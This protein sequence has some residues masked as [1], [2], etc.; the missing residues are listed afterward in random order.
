MVL[1][2]DLY[3]RL[4]ARNDIENLIARYCIACDDRRIEEL[5][6]MFTE[7]AYFGHVDG[8]HG[9]SGRDGVRE[10]YE[11]SLGNMGPSYHWSHDRLIEVDP[12]D[13]NKAT[14]TIL[15]H[16]ETSNAGVAYVAAIRY[17]D[18]YRRVDGVW[19][20]A[21]RGYQFLYFVP[22][23]QYGQALG[24]EK[25]VWRYGAWQLPDLPEPLDSWKEFRAKI[26]KAAA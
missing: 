16:C 2:E 7:D 10:H 6:A 18:R 1:D 15:A 25:R 17:N 13:A 8:V 11:T 24:M 14:G 3:I 23:E 20:F 4:T 12:E 22:A 26:E 19:K 21:W 5:L 9:K